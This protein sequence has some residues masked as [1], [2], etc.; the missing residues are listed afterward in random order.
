MIVLHELGHFIPA[1]YFKTRVE[2]FYLFFDP[3]FSLFKITRGGTEYGIGWL[4]LGGYVKIAGMIDE[5]MDKEQMKKPPEPWEFRSKPAWQ[6]LIIMIGGVTVNVILAVII[7]WMIFFIAGSTYLPN[8]SLTDGIWCTHDLATEVGFKT[9]DKIISVDGKE[10]NRFSRM[11]NKIYVGKEVLVER[12]GKQMLIELPVDLLGKISEAEIKGG[13]FNFRMPFFVS[14]LVE[15]YGAVGSGIEVKDRIIGLNGKEIKYY[16]QFK[17]GVAGLNGQTVKV[18]VDR[19]G[20]VFNY[21]VK[22]SEKGIAGLG[23]A[24]VKLSQLE[25]LGM[26]KLNVQEYTLLEALPAGFNEATET[27]GDYINGLKKLANVETGAYKGVGGFIAIVN[28]FPDHWDWLVFWKLTA[29]LSLMLAVMNLLPIPAL[30]G[31]HVMFLLYE[32]V[33]QRKPNEKFMEYAQ[34][35]GMAMLL[36]L[37]LYANGNDVVGLF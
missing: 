20:E 4:P 36:L 35:T 19:D 26:Y 30:D 5:S 9:G 24:G 23:F 16:D 8:D 17:Q 22:L 10:E 21:D 11:M 29:F 37:L 3:K 13:F 34:L 25:K 33:V 2:K 28:I 1:K 15:G 27:L 12:D 18:T 14:T 6:R 31:G 32:M 7:Y